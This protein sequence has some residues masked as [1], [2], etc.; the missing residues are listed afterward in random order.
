MIWAAA[1]TRPRRWVMR[2]GVLILDARG[3]VSDVGEL[4][5]WRDGENMPSRQVFPWHI[6]NRAGILYSG[7]NDG[8]SAGRRA[9]E[10]QDR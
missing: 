8:N 9:D 6:D 2:S 3:F 10:S 5:C 1:T 7:C 4:R